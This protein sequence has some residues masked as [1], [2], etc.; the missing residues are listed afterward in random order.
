MI[1]ADVGSSWYLTGEAS[2][3]WEARLGGRFDQFL[4][5]IK[6]ITGRD[7]E[8]VVPP[9]G[10]MGASSYAIVGSFLHSNG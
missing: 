9:I 8:V 6:S 5:D 10:E 2:P 4:T 3:L 7:I 1:L